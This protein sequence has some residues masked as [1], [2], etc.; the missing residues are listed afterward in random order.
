MLVVIFT[1]SF[2]I[3]LSVQRELE[4]LRKRFM[5]QGVTE[6]E[7]RDIDLEFSRQNLQLELCLLRHDVKKVGLNLKQKYLDTMSAVQIELSSGRLVGEEKLDEMLQD[8]DAIR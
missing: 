1:L 4:Y 6:R 7:L 3:G 5:S 2:F 8:L